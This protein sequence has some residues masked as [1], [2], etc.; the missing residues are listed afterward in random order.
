MPLTV[1]S[2][3][4]E[5][6]LGVILPSADLTP[7]ATEL[8]CSFCKY[9]SAGGDV[10]KLVR[11]DIAKRFWLVTTA[12][13]GIHELS[14]RITT[15]LIQ[16]RPILSFATQPNIDF[17]DSD[18]VHTC[19][20][21][22]AV[23]RSKRVDFQTFFDLMQQAAEDRGLMDLEEATLDNMLPLQIVQAFIGDFLAGLAR[24]QMF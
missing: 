1:K 4:V 17:V 9:N 5:A 2:N 3:S 10:Q 13:N 16:N 21:M 15:I 11:G 14:E 24:M 8:Y 7:F 20:R 12:P 6:L 19:F 22:C 18:T 23:A